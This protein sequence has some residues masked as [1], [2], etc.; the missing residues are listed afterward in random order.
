MQIIDTT[1][2]GAKVT[3]RWMKDSAVPTARAGGREFWKGLKATARATRDEYRNVR[4][5]TRAGRN[6]SSDDLPY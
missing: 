3:H 6:E 5:D 4:R 1:I 2:A